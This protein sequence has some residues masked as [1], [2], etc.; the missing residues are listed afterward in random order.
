MPNTMIL[1]NIN[2]SRSVCINL[3][4]PV[5]FFLVGIFKSLM[6]PKRHL[7]RLGPT[8]STF[9]I[10]KHVNE[11]DRLLKGHNV[12]SSFVP[13]TQ[14]YSF[15]NSGHVCSEEFSRIRISQGTI[16]TIYVDTGVDQGVTKG[17]QLPPPPPQVF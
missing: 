14:R 7:S 10:N 2:R 5:F 9:W 12:K 13:M 15:A 8:I 4:I 3:Q 11:T 16:D 1:K 6:F 17:G